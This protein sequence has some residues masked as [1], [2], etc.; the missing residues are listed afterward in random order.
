MRIYNISDHP[1][2]IPVQIKY[3]GGTIKPG[4]SVELDESLIPSAAC[5]V[6]ELPSYYSDWKTA[7]TKI[8]PIIFKE[9]QELTPYNTPSSKIIEDF[10]EE[11]PKKK[12]K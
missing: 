9:E 7:P 1:K 5:I 10:L 2:F 8:H 6:T 12:N 3:K 11:K 4:Q